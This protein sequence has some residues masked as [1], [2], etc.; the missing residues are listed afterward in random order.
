MK[1]MEEQGA[2]YDITFLVC[3]TISLL[4]GGIVIMTS[5]WP[6]S[7]RGSGR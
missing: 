1:Q 4:V 6:P 5:C 3:G 2:I 7:T